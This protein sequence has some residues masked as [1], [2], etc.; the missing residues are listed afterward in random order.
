MSGP[1]GTPVAVFNDVF[2][3][4]CTENELFL[5]SHPFDPGLYDLVTAASYNVSCSGVGRC[6]IITGVFVW[7]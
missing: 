4:S 1:G 7:P 5:I 3:V 2:G 6:N